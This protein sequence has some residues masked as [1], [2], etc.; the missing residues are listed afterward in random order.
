MGYSSAFCKGYKMKRILVFVL[1]LAIFFAGKTEKASA[2]GGSLAAS[3]GLSGG[4]SCPV[5]DLGPPDD[6]YFVPPIAGPSYNQPGWIGIPQWLVNGHWTGTPG[7]CWYT[8][9]NV[10]IA[11]SFPMSPNVG[12]PGPGGYNAYD[13]KASNTYSIGYGATPGGSNCNVAS[14]HL[15]I[16]QDASTGLLTVMNW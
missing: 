13:Q 4:T 16:W 14:E 10:P 1:L 7:L 12:P 15:Y 8:W 9:N 3:L 11:V 2:C 5:Q 6:I